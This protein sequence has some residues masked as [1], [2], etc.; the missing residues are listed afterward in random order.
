MA[1]FSK[2]C[3]VDMPGVGTV[4]AGTS[5]GPKWIPLATTVTGHVHRKVG[6]VSSTQAVVLWD[7][8]T[9]SGTTDTDPVTLDKLWLWTDGAGY[10]QLISTSGT[11]TNVIHELIADDPFELPD[12]EILAAANET[13]MSAGAQT[14]QPIQKVVITTSG[15]TAINYVFF[16][17]D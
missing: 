6:N 10:V 9:G 4:H 13:A 3:F 1:V 7:S 17:V 11:G 12:G 2:V 15:S 16:V 8:S 5:T 14:T